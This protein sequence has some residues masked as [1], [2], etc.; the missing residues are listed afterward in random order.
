MYGE[1]V[2]LVVVLGISA[3]YLLNWRASLKKRAQL[4]EIVLEV[5]EN[6]ARSQ[7]A[8][9]LVA[10]IFIMSGKHFLLISYLSWA[11]TTKLKTIIG[12]KS[13]AKISSEK[14]DMEKSL[15]EN[16]LNKVIFPIMKKFIE[17]N[18]MISPVQYLLVFVFFGIKKACKYFVYP[19]SKTAKVKAK[20]H[21]AQAI[22]SYSE[23]RV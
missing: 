17:I 7:T 4:Q 11:L 3:I 6:N 13:C 5:I 10:T 9:D 12:I 8:K 1:I 18:F 21:V 20:T 14:Q 19:N 22:L 2:P 16:E 15:K 23:H